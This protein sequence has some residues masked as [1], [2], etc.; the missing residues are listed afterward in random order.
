[1]ANVPPGGTIRVHLSHS[2][3]PV[4]AVDQAVQGVAANLGGHVQRIEISYMTRSSVSEPLRT[5]TLVYV[6]VGS[7]FQR[8]QGPP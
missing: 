6:R 7:T 5:E 2:T 8:Q 3:V 4:T 1:M